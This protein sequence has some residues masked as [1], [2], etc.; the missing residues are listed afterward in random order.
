MEGQLYSRYQELQRVVQMQTMGSMY[1]VYSQK[2]YE[3]IEH[4][5]Q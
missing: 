4:W 2:L 3:L 5:V 1:F